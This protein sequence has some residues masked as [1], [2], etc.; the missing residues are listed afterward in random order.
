M[1]TL[2][3]AQL[4]VLLSLMLHCSFAQ[5][6]RLLL[7]TATAQGAY[8]HD[9]IPTAIQTITALGKGDISLSSDVAESAVSGARW[10]T[11]ASEDAQLFTQ[12]GLEEFDAIAFV[13]NT[14]V[15]P[16]GIGTILSFDQASAL[17]S[18]ISSGGGY[19]GVHS[20]AN[21]LYSTPGYGRLVGS[22]FDY[23]P[24]LQ[25]VSIGALSK[26]HPS[27]SRFPESLSIRE[28]VYHFRT[29][30]RRLP[31][32]AHVLLTNTSAFQDP[33]VNA[34]GFRNGSD[35]SPRPLAWWRE[36]GLLDV[37]QEERIGGG[38]DDYEGDVNPRGGPGRSFCTSLGHLNETW[39]E[40][41]F[42]AHIAGGIHWV[43]SSPTVKSNTGS[44][45]IGSSGTPTDQSGRP[46]STARDQIGAADVAASPVKVSPG[47]IFLCAVV[48]SSL[49]AVQT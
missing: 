34:Q 11:V 29:D 18:Y 49:W 48:L 44:A 5:G 25:R 20:A 8:R 9:S 12:Q 33:G 26:D 13:H 41:A 47:A 35:G 17:L 46:T 45:S 40:P 21:T 30:P 37:P 1:L 16:P 27:T 38:L 19:V 22:F 4:C 3:S 42:Q 6:A 15:D 28:E 24:A 23:H 2:C 31:S 36:G 14:D 32:P 10:E 7:F 43:L 39:Q